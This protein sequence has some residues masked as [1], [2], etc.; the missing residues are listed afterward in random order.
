MRRPFLC[1]VLLVAP[2]L[3]TTSEGNDF[4]FRQPEMI[5]GQFKQQLQNDLAAGAGVPM[6]VT[7]EDILRAIALGDLVRLPPS[8]WYYPDPDLGAGYPNRELMYYVRPWAVTFLDEIGKEYY[9]LFGRPLKITSLVRTMARQ[10]Q[11]QERNAN[12]QQDRPS[13]HLFGN[14]VD[15]SK[16]EMSDEELQW[17]R[18]TL[19]PLIQQERVVV[20]EEM[21]IKNFHVFVVPPLGW[22]FRPPL[23]NDH[24][25]TFS[26]F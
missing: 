26:L 1:G 19:S 21:N 18:R 5:G 15:I 7:D 11:L 24:S 12:A 14:T 8:L 16:L 3:P 13:A 6:L 23:P 9:R 20:I 25:C 4:S 22:D 2:L 10:R 17:I